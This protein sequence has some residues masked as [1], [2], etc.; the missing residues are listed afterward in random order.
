MSP[1]LVVIV[2]SSG[3][4][5]LFLFVIYYFISLWTPFAFYLNRESF[6]FMWISL[7]LSRSTFRV[8]QF[9]KFF[10]VCASILL[11]SPSDS[12][13]ISVGLS[14]IVVQ[15]TS[16]QEFPLSTWCLWIFLVHCSH[17]FTV[18]S[19]GYKVIVPTLSF[20]SLSSNYD[21]PPSTWFLSIS[22]ALHCRCFSKIRVAYVRIS[23]VFVSNSLTITTFQ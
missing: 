13:N 12:F 7:L 17:F 1:C 22:F 11:L 21:F 8:S 14:H 2:L 3:L 6:Y 18:I 23:H 10:Q 19:S 16:N 9:S 5:S 15:S 4:V 20:I